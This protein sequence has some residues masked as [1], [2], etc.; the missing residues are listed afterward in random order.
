MNRKLQEAYIVAA[1]RTPIG[2][3]PRGTLRNTRPD[4]LLVHT[5][6]SVLSKVPQLDKNLIEDLIVGCAMPEGEQGCNVARMAVL[7]AGL[8]NTIGGVTVNR[9]CASG[10]TA[11]A[12]AADRIQT[13]QADVMIAAGVESMS[14]VPMMGYH[15][16]FNPHIFENDEA[17]GLAYGMGITAENVAQQWKISREDQDQFSMSSHQKAVQAQTKNAFNDEICPLTLTSK[18][19]GNKENNSLSSS[20]FSK[21]EG[22]RSDTSIEKLSKLKPAFA[23]GGSVTAGNSSQMSDGA[24]AI[25]L[26]SEKMLKALNL[27]PMARWLSFAIRGVP[28]SWALVLKLQFR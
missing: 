10:L 16:S 3:A 18:E 15:P 23:Q 14:R 19:Q 22:P 21:D 27:S 2:K 4:D 5:L 24:G 7:L 11:I 9:L 1:V 13:G 25:I 28:I 20:L 17:L 6:Q 26:V 8:P 12:M